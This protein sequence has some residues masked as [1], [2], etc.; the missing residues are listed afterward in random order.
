MRYFASPPLY[1]DQ[2]GYKTSAREPPLSATPCVRCGAQHD[3][4]ASP[5]TE[6][7]LV[8]RTLH[9]GIRVRERLRDTPLGPLYRAEYPTGREV[10]V[11][12]LGSPSHDSGALALLRQRCLDAIQIQHPNVAAIYELSETDDGLVYVVA[13]FLRGELL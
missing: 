2:L 11:V 13:E 6:P 9:A 1:R 8:G 7:S 12:L 3:P 4:G 5:C 10:A